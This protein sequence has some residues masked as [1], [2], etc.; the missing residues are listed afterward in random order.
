MAKRRRSRRSKRAIPAAFRL[1]WA[2]NRRKA[3][4]VSRRARRSI[5]RV[6]RAVAVRRRRRRRGASKG[7]PMARRRRRSFARGGAGRRGFFNSGL[8]LKAALGGI[9]G[10]T[11][12]NQLAPRLAAALPDGAVGDFAAGT[13]GQVLVGAVIGIAGGLALRKVGQTEMGT[14]FALGAIVERGAG[15]LRTK[16]AEWQAQQAG[17]NGLGAYGINGLGAYGIEG[18]G[19]GDY[20]NAPAPM[21]S[22]YG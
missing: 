2:K 1:Q 7:F 14:A 6:I 9:A 11:A 18:L 16:L 4:K 22:P 10:A 21:G 8:T 3:K 19:Q 17:V 20:D 5:R 12:S 15:L 13:L